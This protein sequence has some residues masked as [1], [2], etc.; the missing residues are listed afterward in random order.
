MPYWKYKEQIF[1]LPSQG[2][3]EGCLFNPEQCKS[4]IYRQIP[5]LGQSIRY[6]MGLDCPLFPVQDVM[7]PSKEAPLPSAVSESKKKFFLK[8]KVKF[9]LK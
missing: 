8:K 1:F 3:C 9:N 5:L 2:Y 7:E 6:E 4:S